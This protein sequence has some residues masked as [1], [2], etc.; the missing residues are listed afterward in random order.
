MLRPRKAGAKRANPT[1]GQPSTTEGTDR[2]APTCYLSSIDCRRSPRFRPDAE[3]RVR[4]RCIGRR[5]IAIG[6]LFVL[7]CSSGEAHPPELG[8]CKGE[9][10]GPPALGFGSGGNGGGASSEGGGS[11]GCPVNSADSQCAQ[12]ASAGCCAPLT[13]CSA[14][15]DC[16]NLWNCETGCGGVATCVSACD[17][18]YP[19]S[20]ATL[21]T[22]GA[23]LMQMCPVCSQLGVGDPCMPQGT[24][25]NLGLSCSGLWCT[26]SCASA[27]DCAGL[28]A[29]GGNALNLGS[30]CLQSGGVGNQCVPG[31]T[32]DA[33]CTAFLGTYRVS[34]TSVDGLAVNVCAGLPDAGP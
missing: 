18:Q 32:T 20:V 22:L 10:C 8:N 30:A 29:N 34:T 7:A 33:D 25:C 24:A 14:S 17:R 4:R 3:A 6:C 5:S 28:G 16:Q 31:C 11:S 1:K 13:A 12:C 21:S 9:A 23:C 15:A 2:R 19:N 27:S 26:K